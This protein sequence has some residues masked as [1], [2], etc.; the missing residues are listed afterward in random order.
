VIR[1]FEAVC[2]LPLDLV[3]LEVLIV[4]KT[5]QM[6]RASGTDQT[7]MG[8]QVEVESVGVGNDRVNDCTSRLG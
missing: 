6:G 3:H 4:P 7:S 5:N 2:K 8:L 1:A